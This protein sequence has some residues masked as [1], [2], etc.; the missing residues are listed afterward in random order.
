[1]PPNLLVRSYSFGTVTIDERTYRSDVIIYRDRVDANWWRAEGHVLAFADLAGPVAARPDLLVVG[2][3]A[4]GVMQVPEETR[5][6]LEE[7]GI[8][9]VVERTAKAV[10]VYNEHRK[11]GRHV[12][13]ALH[14]TC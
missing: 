3:G 1:M 11:Q 14:L 9:L 12:I 2:S 7:R 8:G 5:R 10:E 6:S 4:F 13:A